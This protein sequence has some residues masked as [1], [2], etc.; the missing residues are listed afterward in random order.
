MKNTDGGGK[1][2]QAGVLRETHR[3]LAICLLQPRPGA[4]VAWELCISK[5]EQSVFAATAGFLDLRCIP[6]RLCAISNAMYSQVIDD[7]PID[8]SHK[9][10]YRIDFKTK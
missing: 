3:P 2:I 4:S 8:N 9:A 5:V 7:S 1:W 10:Y 6:H